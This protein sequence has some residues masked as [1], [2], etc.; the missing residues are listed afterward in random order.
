VITM[1]KRVLLGALAVAAAMVTLAGC[2]DAPPPATVVVNTPPSDGPLVLLTV[3]V[4]AAFVLAGVAVVSGWGWASERRARRAA[5]DARRD[6]EEAV[7]ALTGQPLRRARVL[8]SRGEV[9][10][11][12]WPPAGQSMQRWSE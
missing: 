9:G 12:T 6:A 7:I 5:E 10:A 11:G 1:F 4:A 2:T 8:I 3:M